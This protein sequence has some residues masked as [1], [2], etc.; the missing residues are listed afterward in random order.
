MLVGSLCFSELSPRPS[1]VILA[2][3]STQADG[4][5]PSLT[6]QFRME[7]VSLH[8]TLFAVE[9]S[10]TGYLQYFWINSIANSSHLLYLAKETFYHYFRRT[11]K[12]L[13]QNTCLVIYMDTYLKSLLKLSSETHSR[14]TRYANFNLACPIVQRQKEGERTFTVTTCK[15]WNTLPLTTRTLA[16]LL[17]WKNIFNRF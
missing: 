10:F 7:N 14:Q 1:A 12:L 13:S 9:I 2:F 4:L 17:V 8:C 16:T 6:A 5:Y 3:N 15:L 11:N